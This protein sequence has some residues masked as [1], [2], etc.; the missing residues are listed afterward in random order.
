MAKWFIKFVVPDFF[1]QNC[2]SENTFHQN[3]KLFYNF[4]W[5]FISKNLYFDQKL[6]SPNPPTNILNPKRQHFAFHSR[7]RKQC[8]RKRSKKINKMT[9][10]PHL[11]TELFLPVVQIMDKVKRKEE[12]RNLHVSAKFK[13]NRD[14]PENAVQKGQNMQILC[15]RERY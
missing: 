4:L 2:F 7:E 8:N 1:S 10:P 15:P 13:K 3:I 6:N 5:S 9:I 12:G 14:I 11:W